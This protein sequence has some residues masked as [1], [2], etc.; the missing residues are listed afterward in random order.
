MAK[1]GINKV[2]LVGNL[3]RDPEVR[4][5]DN[6]VAVANFTIATTESIRRAD[7]NRE[8]RT[9]WHNIVMWRGLAETAGKYLRK[10][11]TVYLEGKI[12]TRSWESD[13]VKKYRTEVEADKMVMLDSRGSGPDLG[14]S[15]AGGITSTPV[16]SPPATKSPGSGQAP[17]KDFSATE[18]LEDDDLPF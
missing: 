16:T 15:Q 10:G 2:I 11:S 4:H 18:N 6:G 12:I 13:G 14:I 9:E 17:G 5:L 7:G 8:D 1:Y 3:G